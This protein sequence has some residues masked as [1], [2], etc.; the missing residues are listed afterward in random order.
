MNYN[1]LPA[2]D[3][4]NN[5]PLI[6]TE[7]AAGIPE[8]L[9]VDVTQSSLHEWLDPE[10]LADKPKGETEGYQL[11]RSIDGDAFPGRKVTLVN[12]TPHNSYRPHRHMNSDAVF[13][14]VGGRATL[15]SDQPKRKVGAGDIIPAP[16]GM[17]H[18]FDL[19]PD[20]TLAWVSIQYPPIHNAETGEDD[21][22][23]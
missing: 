18:G 14:V 12:I 23:F 16:R 6:N 13:I 3:S 15:L 10:N 5:N 19:E 20:E 1:F 4:T 21:L 7:Q 11:V 2:L 9:L 17:A 8:E 22:H